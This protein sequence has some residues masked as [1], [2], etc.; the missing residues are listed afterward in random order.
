MS[1]KPRGAQ[2][3]IFDRTG[4]VL[5]LPWITGISHGLPGQKII[6]TVCAVAV[7]SV[8]D[9]PSGIS[10]PEVVPDRGR[11]I[12]RKRVGSILQMASC[13]SLEALSSSRPSDGGRRRRRIG[14]AGTI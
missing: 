10:Q 13:S 1:A 4:R 14:K 3:G 12:D 6:H 7:A 5:L 9:G 2:V 8:R 11:G